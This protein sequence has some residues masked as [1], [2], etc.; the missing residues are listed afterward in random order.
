MERTAPGAESACYIR[1]YLGL[2]TAKGFWY[3]RRLGL[4]VGSMALRPLRKLQLR[5]GRL[6]GGGADGESRWGG[7]GGEE[8]KQ[9]QRKVVD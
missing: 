9:L 1:K 3:I 4:V 6:R 8:A 7:G 5:D 2:C